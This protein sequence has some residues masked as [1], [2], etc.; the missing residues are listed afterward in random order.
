METKDSDPVAKKM[1]TD[2]K[3]A[4]RID[5]CVSQ[6]LRLLS[7]LVAFTRDFVMDSNTSPRLSFSLQRDIQRINEEKWGSELQFDEFILETIIQWIKLSGV[8]CREGLPRYRYR[9]F[10]LDTASEVSSPTKNIW[11]DKARSVV[12]LLCD[13]LRHSSDI[14]SAFRLSAIE[15]S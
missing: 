6:K 7:T 10:G 2:S 5:A 11:P 1:R 12:R 8:Q 13:S 14:S 4:M 9:I 3:S 15:F